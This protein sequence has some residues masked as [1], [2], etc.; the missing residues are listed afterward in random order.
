MSDLTKI[1]KDHLS[2]RVQ[3][4]EL[5]N[6]DITDII[7]SLGCYLNLETYSDYSKRTKLDYNSVKARVKSGKIKEYILF[8][9]KFIIDND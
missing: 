8:N 2:K 9:T 4:N 7:D 1:I 3:N 5:K 6:S